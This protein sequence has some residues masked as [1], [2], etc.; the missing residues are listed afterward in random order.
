V[1]N[2]CD[3]LTLALGQNAPW[4]IALDAD[5]IYWTNRGTSTDGSVVKLPKTGGMPVSLATALHF[6][7]GIAVNGTTVLFGG[8]TLGIVSVPIDGG[9]T[10]T[11]VPSDAADGGGVE[12]A[13]D[14]DFVYWT[15]AGA[16]GVVMKA[17]LDGG[18]VTT[19]AYNL[20]SPS[21]FAI[22]SSYVYWSEV[23]SGTV[24]KV[25]VGGGGFTTLASNQG[26]TLPPALAVDAFN[27]Y[28]PV[29]SGA[30]MS[31]QIAGGDPSTF[32]PASA[33][34]VTVAVDDTYVYFGSNNSA[35]YKAPKGGG[36]VALLAAATPG[37][38]AGAMAVDDKYVY[39]CAGASGNGIVRK[40]AK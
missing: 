25:S 33:G 32:L 2:V 27:V 17:T 29:S 13:V 22:D 10:A 15:N 30:I 20:A 24:R 21:G 26:I 1:S 7:G 12:L 5:N 16:P 11:V 4:A 38:G 40:V 19:L 37:G 3:A 34:A 8:F 18:S 14:P 28:W 6:P 35:V 39:W 31:V 9:P 23:G 36:P